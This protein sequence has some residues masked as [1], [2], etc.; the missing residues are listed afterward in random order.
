M[1]SEHKEAHAECGELAAY[2][3]NEERCASHRKHEKGHKS[4]EEHN[5]GLD[6]H[7][8]RDD[9]TT[10]CHREYGNGNVSD[11]TQWHKGGR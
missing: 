5:D 3:P 10:V 11:R 8:R 6:T 9:W 2:G 4:A 1:A 7:L